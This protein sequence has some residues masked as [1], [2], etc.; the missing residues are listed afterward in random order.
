M[1]GFDLLLKG[2]DGQMPVTD[3]PNP[4]TDSWRILSCFNRTEGM[5]VHLAENEAKMQGIA[6]IAPGMGAHAPR[7]DMMP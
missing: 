1:D 6:K 7:G 4:A 3:A 5:K 2:F